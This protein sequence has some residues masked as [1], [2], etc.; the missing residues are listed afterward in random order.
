MTSFSF[1]F[2]A[3]FALT[4]IFAGTIL[5]RYVVF[6][7]PLMVVILIGA[8]LLLVTSY[9]RL[10]ARYF[11]IS[12]I[13]FLLFGSYLMASQKYQYFA[14]DDIGQYVSGSGSVRIFGKI[15]KWPVLKQHKTILTCRADSI[16]VRDSVRP[17]SGSILVN[18]RR[19]T[20][21]FMLGDAVSFSGRL[22][23]PS[24]G[25]YPGQFDYREYL[26]NKGIRGIVYISNPVLILKSEK[27]S[28]VWG[29][30]IS[31]LRKWV[32]DCFQSNL[33]EIPNA[34]AS[35]FLI[36]ETRDIPEDIYQ[37]F[38][39]TGTLHL[40]AVSGSNVALVLIV[41][42]VFLKV[43]AFKKTTR[44]LIL[45][46]V[47]VVFS[48]LSNNQPSVI[49]A[50]V[51]AILIIFVRF[52][53]RRADLNNIIAAAACLLI[54][55]DP[56][57]LFDIGFQ[58]SFAVTWG[59]ILFLPKVNSLLVGYSISS[60]YRYLLL[61]TGCSFIASLVSAPITLFYFGEMSLVT[62]FSNLLIVPLVSVA[63]IGIMILLTVNLIFP[64][65]AII[66][67]ALL[68]R[69]LIIINELVIWFG[70]W[71]FSAIRMAE[72]KGEYSIF[73][74]I[75]LTMV[76]FAIT[77]KSLRRLLVFSILLGGVCF[78]GEGIFA[79]EKPIASIEIYNRGAT[80][81]VI[82]NSTNRLAIFHQS[83]ASRYDDFSANLIPYLTDRD[84]PFPEIFILFEPKY[85]TWQRMAEGSEFGPDIVL[86]PVNEFNFSNPSIWSIAEKI[87]MVENEA[88]YEIQIGPN[89]ALIQISDSSEIIIADS[90]ADLKRLPE[91]LINHCKW[92][93]IFIN[94]DKS[95]SE[96]LL[97]N[98]TDKAVILFERHERYYK[99]W[100]DNDFD[101][102][103]PGMN[104]RIILS[105]S[106]ITIFP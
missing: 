59:L 82:I 33:T 18:V 78:F 10:D 42:S 46:S 27:E 61:V 52:L 41:I 17:A 9:F 8:M 48:H 93:I 20:T 29:K 54:L 69:L 88:I 103:Y 26:A 22:Y 67:G 65:L 60:A 62:V 28:N 80:Q 23:N 66:A 30:A 55:Y 37:A 101:E 2:P 49:R 95:L 13:L 104:D 38:R 34:L 74:L 43:F 76:F 68:D 53:Y 72:V 47:V 83:R 98:D 89:V 87:R 99:I 94:S 14:A 21:E 19:E 84:E 32:L 73:A 92:Y 24:G 1:R 5:G 12:L 91:S 85:R 71:E 106:N 50:S 57:N 102:L 70:S 36:G 97:R 31:S 7:M 44:L 86:Y 6:S 81:S 63:V 11:S 100:Q 40:L 75:I 105:G 4:G 64:P 56:A 79:K 58:L 16:I 39:R 77:S 25:N 35:G 15:E 45:I 96:L 3:V 51:M 90:P